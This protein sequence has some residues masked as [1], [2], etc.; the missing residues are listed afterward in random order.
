MK[1][2]HDSPLL[3]S[4]LYKAERGGIYIDSN[5]KIINLSI[6][7]QKLNSEFCI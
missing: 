1:R 3:S 4:P 7:N 6:P 2:F 5:S